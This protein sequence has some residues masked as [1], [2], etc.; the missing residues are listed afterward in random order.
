MPDGSQETAPVSLKDKYP[1]MFEDVV[2]ITGG[3]NKLFSSGNDFLAFYEQYAQDRY[4]QPVSFPIVK[5]KKGNI[6]MLGADHSQRRLEDLLSA[7]RI[8]K[9]DISV[10]CALTGLVSPLD[11]SSHNN[12]LVPPFITIIEADTVTNADNKPI[13]IIPIQTGEPEEG[14]YVPKKDDYDLYQEIF[15]NM[16]DVILSP[17][18]YT[19]QQ[20]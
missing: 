17:S 12:R 11:V 4:P 3:L 8:D 14:R 15:N 19:L 10:S 7:M 2:D 9:N 1:K 18:D 5:T 16:K 20:T 6:F 13:A